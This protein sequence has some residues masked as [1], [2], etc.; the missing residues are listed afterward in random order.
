MGDKEAEAFGRFMLFMGM[1]FGSVLGAIVVSVG[2]SWYS[3]IPASFICVGIAYG[4]RCYYWRNA[5]KEAKDG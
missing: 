4:V 3:V 2:Y 1:A 5:G